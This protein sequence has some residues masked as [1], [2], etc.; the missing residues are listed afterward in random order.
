MGTGEG[1]VEW[2]LLCM[3]PHVSSKR[4]SA[5]V[6]H[7]LP[8]TVVPFTDVPRSPDANVLVMDVLDQVIHVSQINIASV[9]TTYR[10]LFCV[11]KLISFDRRSWNRAGG[12]GGDVGEVCWVRVV[13]V[14]MVG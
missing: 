12:V 6:C 3:A 2:L 14:V 13:V 5:R 8:A 10:N 9:P 1:A 11:L 4:I 7:A